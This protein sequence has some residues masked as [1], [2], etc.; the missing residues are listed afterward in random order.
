MP[1]RAREISAVIF[2]H[3]PCLLDAVGGGRK[4]QPCDHASF[5]IVDTGTDARHAN[6]GFLV[7]QGITELANAIKFLVQR[8]KVADGVLGE[9]LKAGAPGIFLAFFRTV[10]Q[11][12]D[13]PAAVMCK[14]ARAPIRWT[15]RMAVRS[16]NNL[17]T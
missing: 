16:D 6:L 1:D 4:R 17:S 11:K 15:T 13:F 14:G 9:H 7:V 12:E 8:G 3:A 2:P 10:F 5:V